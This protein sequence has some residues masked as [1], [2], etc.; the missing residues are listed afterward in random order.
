MR[1]SIGQNSPVAALLG[2]QAVLFFEPAAAQLP[3]P[4]EAPPK[5][6]TADLGAPSRRVGPGPPPPS[7]RALKRAP[8]D[9][10]GIDSAKW[11]YT[12]YAVTAARLSSVAAMAAGLTGLVR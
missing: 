7:R 4:E 6:P 12:P 1:R 10:G 3:H 2:G 5:S 9:E 8:Q 11:I